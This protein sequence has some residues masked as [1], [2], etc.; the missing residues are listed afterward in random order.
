MTKAADQ[1]AVELTPRQSR[2]SGRPTKYTDQMPDLV[3]ESLASGD[4]V[5]QFAVSIGVHR[6]TIYAW[7]DSHP[8]FSDALTR[9]QEASQA[10][11]EGELRQ[12]MYSK[13]VNAP[14]VKLYF[15]NRFNWHDKS[16]V[17]NKSTDGSMT[18]T[19]IERRVVDPNDETAA[20]DS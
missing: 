11:W 8:E 14:L 10:F 16:E 19:V 7:A 15:A 20:A 2:R 9:G 13:E 1:G 3:Y 12:M 18:P 6:D 5:T 4:S 17:D